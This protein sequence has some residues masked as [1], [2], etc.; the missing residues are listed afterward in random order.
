MKSLNKL[1][2]K[3]KMKYAQGHDEDDTSSLG[4]SQEV[5]A[6]EESPQKPPPPPP[7]QL[8][9]KDT[10]LISLKTAHKIVTEIL[11]FVTCDSAPSV[12]EMRMA[13]FQQV[14]SPALCVSIYK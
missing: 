13:L 1:G 6:E 7:A 12:A 4:S 3:V 8:P 10:S 5:V 9:T 11:E 14:Y 2:Q